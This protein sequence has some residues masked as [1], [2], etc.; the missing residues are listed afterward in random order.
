MGVRGFL[1]AVKTIEGKKNKLKI[2]FSQNENRE[3]QLAAQLLKEREQKL[4]GH[5]ND[6]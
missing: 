3:M 2:V 6:N 1:Y 5:Q 4:P